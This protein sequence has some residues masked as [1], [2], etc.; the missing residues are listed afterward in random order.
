MRVV[1]HRLLRIGVLVPLL[2]RSLING[3]QL[4][5]L[6]RVLASPLES[7]LLLLLAHGEVELDQSDAALD[8]HLFQHGR[9]IQELV[10][11]LQRTEL[12]HSLNAGAVVPGAVE[13]CQLSTRWQVLHIALEVPLTAL[14]L[15]GFC[16]RDDVCTAG[17]QV[18][19]EAADSSAFAGCVSPFEH[20]DYSL[21]CLV[22]P[23]LHLHQLDLQRKLVLV[24]L[25]DA[26]LL[27]VW[28]RDI[29]EHLPTFLGFE[30]LLMQWGAGTQ[31]LGPIFRLLETVSVLHP[32]VAVCLL[33]GDLFDSL[34]DVPG[35]ILT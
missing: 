1:E 4:P 2:Q 17:I 20:N 21:A 29:K 25:L 30:Y 28:V 6:Q 31:Y 14:L 13:Q 33:P 3:T 22:Y 5:S 27:L 19:H 15:R 11:F 34:G 9:L 32:V 18:L 10:R 24:V 12:H 35:S 23:I 7:P 26:Q 8:P 16:Q